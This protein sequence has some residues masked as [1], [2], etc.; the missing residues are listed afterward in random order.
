MAQ[1]ETPAIPPRSFPL[2]SSAAI[3]LPGAEK[4]KNPTN[5]K[6]TGLQDRRTE[7]D[8]FT[9]HGYNCPGGDLCAVPHFNPLLTCL[10]PVVLVLLT[11]SVRKGH[12][13]WSHLRVADTASVERQINRILRMAR[14]TCSKSVTRSSLDA[15]VVHCLQDA[16]GN[17]KRKGTSERSMGLQKP[18]TE[19]WESFL[20]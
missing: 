2:A 14:L 1:T 15:G 6:E 11:H 16:S 19:L 5:S 7:V 10:T 13:I 18:S 8:L 17:L 20:V 9:R 4:G 12:P 3:A